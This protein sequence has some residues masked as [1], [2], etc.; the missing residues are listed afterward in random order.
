[1][2]TEG[3]PGELRDQAV[4]LVEVATVVREDH[5]RGAVRLEPFEVFLDRHALIGE[6]ALPEV[7]DDDLPRSRLAEEALRAAHGL[8]TPHLVGREHHPVHAR[9]RYR[10]E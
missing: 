8:R 3:I 2:I 1:M 4:V 5:V 10:L 7:V 9:A 6:E